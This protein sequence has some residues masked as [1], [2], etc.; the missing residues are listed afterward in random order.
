MNF[1]IFPIVLLIFLQ[2]DLGNA[3]IYIIACVLALFAFGFPFK[4][5][6]F[7]FLAWLAT[8]PLFWLILHDY[9]RQRV[10]VFLDPSNDPLG[11]SYN[12][13]QSIIAVGSGMFSGRG[14]GQGTQSVLKFLPEHHTDFIF[15][16]ISE[17]LGF[18][19]AAIIVLSFS[20]LL[21]RIFMIYSQERDNFSQIFTII[22]FFIFFTHFVVNVGMNIG[23]L[24]V[25]GVTLP[26][27]SSG[28]SSLLSNFII[29]GLLFAV[30]RTDT[31]RDTLEIR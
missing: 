7:G 15:A 12:S 5:F 28:G 13:I 10:L 11:T 14:F 22:V 24:P 3:L 17:Q 30:S 16:A 20:F 18:I 26:F 1:P 31:K 9:Q 19:G 25:V 29:L 4:Y 21:Y 6:F 2:P 27:I 23:L 8:L